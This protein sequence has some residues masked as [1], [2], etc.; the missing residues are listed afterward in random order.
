MR[1]FR[2]RGRRYGDPV[3]L[4]L[5]VTGGKWKMPILWRVK[6]RAW[7]YGELKRDLGR[8]THKMLTQQ[9]RELE[10]DGLVRRRIYVV[11]PPR[12][13]YSITPLGMS[14]LAA[15]EAMRAWGRTYRKRGGRR[16]RLRPARARVG[17]A[18][19]A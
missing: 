11:V 3:E 14:S 1:A 16:R 12:V 9:L 6:G 10:A 8:V 13:E 7:R 15:V 4:A 18:G 19:A 17:A 5:E 2:F